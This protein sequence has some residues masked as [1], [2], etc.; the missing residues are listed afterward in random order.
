[1]NLQNSTLLMGGRGNYF[2]GKGLPRSV[3]G[4]YPLF[5]AFCWQW[6][7]WKSAIV[8]IIH[9][10]HPASAHLSRR[11]PF[12]SRR[13]CRGHRMPEDGNHSKGET[14]L[15]SLHISP[16]LQVQPVL[17]PDQSRPAAV[18]LQSAA[19]NIIQNRAPPPSGP[20]PRDYD[21]TCCPRTPGGRLPDLV[22]GRRRCQWDATGQ[23]R[24]ATMFCDC[25]EPD[26]QVNNRTSSPICGNLDYV[27]PHSTSAMNAAV[28]C[29]DGNSGRLIDIDT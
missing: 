25:C 26:E 11:N 6:S 20:G 18:R 7:E 29:T 9:R 22:N 16:Q 23:C 28:W 15:W 19:Q 10:K 2:A 13:I 21:P 3:V 5:V 4:Q 14:A 27:G 12:I 17:Y 24:V 8:G 1:M